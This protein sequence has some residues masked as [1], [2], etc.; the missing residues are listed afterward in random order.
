MPYV[1]LLI[2]SLKYELY[3]KLYVPVIIRLYNLANA[4]SFIISELQLLIRV[5]KLG[6]TFSNDLIGLQ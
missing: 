3:Q 4:V 6:P 5:K 2:A 1:T